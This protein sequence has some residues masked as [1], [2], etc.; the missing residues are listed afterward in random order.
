MTPPHFDEDA[1]AAELLQH[2][3]PRVV[4]QG[5]PV[6]LKLRTGPDGRLQATAVRRAGGL[7][8]LIVGPSWSGAAIVATGRFRVLDESHEPPALVVPGLAGGLTL[9]CV[10]SRRDVTGWRLRLPDGSCF[11]PVPEAGFMMDV[12]RRSLQM[13]TDPPPASSGPLLL[14]AWVAAIA[15]SAP[16]AGR[17]WSWDEAVHMHP[18]LADGPRLDPSSAEQAIRHASGRREW[19]AMRQLVAAGIAGRQLPP[20]DL[21]RWMDAGMFARWVLGSLPPA[22]EM[23]VA[24]RPHLEPA[25]WR[26]LVHLARCVDD[27]IYAR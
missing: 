9:A 10:L 24:A 7:L 17:Q 3:R 16:P 15:D 18:A 21:A 1:A 12:L 23:V 13:D 2:Y 22:E 26:R 11:D 25:A 8:G 6:G 5:G 14:A 27:R 20:P 19:E 4:R